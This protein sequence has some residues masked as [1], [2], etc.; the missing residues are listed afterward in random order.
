MHKFPFSSPVL[1]LEKKGSVFSTKSH[2]LVNSIPGLRSQSMLLKS[3][4]L[5][6]DSHN[7]RSRRGYK[8][9]TLHALDPDNATILV[10]GGGGVGL[11]TVKLLRDMGAWTYMLQRSDIRRT[12]LEALNVII[13]KADALDEAKLEE[14]ILK[15][16]GLDAVVSAL[17]GTKNDPKV[18]SIGNVNLIRAAVK[19]KVQKFVL[20][21]S[22]GA[23][24]SISSISES[25]FKYLEPVLIEKTKAEEELKTHGQELE[26]VIIRPAHLFS[27][28]GTGCGVLTEDVEVGG[29]LHREDCAKLIVEALFSNRTSNKVEISLHFQLSNTILFVP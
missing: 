2:V 16:D 9:H 11:E 23:G 5:S 10:T 18:D 13:V 24:G 21:S 20:V 28:P 22:V 26:Y 12:E 17:G 6:L 15:I 29:R 7:T 25:G 4:K 8:F 14:Q 27:K 1:E 19:A 3:G